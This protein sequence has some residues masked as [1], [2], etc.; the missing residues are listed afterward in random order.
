MAMDK[1]IRDFPKQLEWKPKIENKEAFEK[2]GKFEKFALSGMGGSHHAAEI[3]LDIEPEI[4]LIVRSD[5]GLFERAD[6]KEKKTLII[7]SSYS[8]NTEEPIDTFHIAIK[9]GLPVVAMAK[10]GKVI[11]HAKAIGVPYIVIPDTGIQPRSGLGFS[12]LAML[13]LMGKSD[14]LDKMSNLA[15]SV[16]P[17]KL[18]IAG[19]ELADNIR[20]KAP[21][22]YASARNHSVAQLAKIKFNETGKIPAYYNVIPELNHN[23][24]T[25]YDVQDSSRKLSENIVFIF[26][27]D[28]NDHKKNIKRME[29]SAKLL[30]DRGFQVA[31]VVMI[32]KTQL[33]K[34]FNTLILADWTAFYTGEGYG[35]ETEQV[36]MVEEF[37][38]LIK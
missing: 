7:I 11:Q 16:N 3:L 14:L 33:E 25:G 38:N 28:S 1:A 12:M 27:K 37:K 36:P 19:K 8:G 18:E 13:K 9:S 24:L 23:E 26:F 29:V 35:L 32:G 22:I 6:V 2:L 30:L 20:G 17:E 21:I 10:G 15:K 5:Y 34:I 4:D 31:E